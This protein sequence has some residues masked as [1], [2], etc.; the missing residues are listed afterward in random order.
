MLFIQSCGSHRDRGIE[1]NEEPDDA[2]VLDEEN[3]GL[4]NIPTDC[5]FFIA[6]ATTKGRLS[7]C[8]PQT[9]ATFIQSLMENRTKISRMGARCSNEKSN[10]FCF[11]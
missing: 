4:V 5:D 7:T 2:N 3:D 1:I 8:H 11:A 9:G 6:Y 10:K